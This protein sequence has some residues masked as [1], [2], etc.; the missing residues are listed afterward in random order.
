MKKKLRLYK[1]F[2]IFMFILLF[3]NFSTMYFFYEMMNVRRECFP[4]TIEEINKTFYYYNFLGNEYA[5]NF[6]SPCVI[7]YMINIF[8]MS[9]FYALCIN[10]CQF[11]KTINLSKIIFTIIFMLIVSYLLFIL[12]EFVKNGKSSYSFNF[13]RYFNDI[14]IFCFI[15]IITTV[16]YFKFMFIIYPKKATTLW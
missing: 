10:Y 5:T 11:Y 16:I 2:F 7:R 4:D 1:S 12:M 6:F 9:F 3:V 15:S 8:F 13:I 14:L